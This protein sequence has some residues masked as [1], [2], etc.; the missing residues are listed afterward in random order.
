MKTKSILILLF[1]FTYQIGV[2]QC[3]NPPANVVSWWAADNNALDSKDDN[4]GT[5]FNGVN[6]TSGMV[7]QSFL[8]DGINDFV[9]VP[10]SENLDISGDI[11][12]MLW[13]RRIGYANQ[14]QMVICKGAGYVPNDEPAVF[15]M[16]F[17][18]D[19]TEFLFEDTN[20]NNI[21]LNG[22][23]YEDSLYHHYVYVRE[24]NQHRLYVDGFLFDSSTFALPP[25]STLGLPLTIG[26]QYHNP[27]NNADD[28]DFYFHGEIDEIGLFN[29]ALSLQEIEDVYNAGAYGVCKEQ[30][31][32]AELNKE[33]AVTIYPMP[34]DNVMHININE[35]T[36]L[37]LHK[38]NL[39]ILDIRGQTIL[40]TEPL[41]SFNTQ[42]DMSNLS[43]GVYLYRLVNNDHILKVGK[44]IKK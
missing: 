19:V 18:F 39:E 3:V 4:H 35:S 7:D 6:Y 11:T 27:M 26:A 25:A 1:F 43:S 37:E 29:R 33:N 21:I 10:D 40:E 38:T 5:E 32:I 14:H 13:V 28:Y 9:F 42:Y 12:V 36:A 31:S 34:I 41:T 24:A 16:R 15:A 30:L 17:E 8:F 22:P 44:L 2:S 23:A 20:G